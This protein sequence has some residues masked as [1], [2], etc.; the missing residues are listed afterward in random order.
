MYKDTIA[1][2]ATAMTNSGIGIVR[3]SGEDSF[4]IIDKIYHS[5]GNKKKLS[6]AESHTVHYGYI[7]DGTK[8]IDEV[9]VLI[10]KSPN[11]YTMEDTV[12][13]DC[14]GGSLVMKRVLETVIKYGARLAEP[15]EFTKRAFLNGRI[16][17]SQAESVMDLINAKN[18]F[19]LESSINQL[20][21]SIKEKIKKIRSKIIYQIAYIESALDDPEHISIDGYGEQLFQIVEELSNQ[22]EDMLIISENG[23]LLKEGINTVIIGKPNVGKS[24]LMNILAG[25]ERAIVTEIAGT[26]R[27]VLEEQI[28]LKGITLNL[29]DTAGIHDTKDIVE[30]IGVDKAKEFL[31][32]ADLVIYVADSSTVLD[33]DDKEILELLKYKK[34]V[35][36][37]NKT[38]LKQIT[39]EEKM[40]K[41]IKEKEIE[42]PVLSISAKKGIGIENLEKIVKDL[43]FSGEISFNDEIYIT[44]VRH[45]SL[46][47]SALKSLSNVKKSI[48]DDMPEDFYYIDLMS[49]YE[50]L[51]RIIGEA[52]GEDLVN[53]IFSRFC[54]GK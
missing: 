43:F 46:L 23:A 11:T 53:E 13:I 10:L 40:R 3:I 22:I 7:Y 36:L 18:N 12:E 21:G 47:Q 32:R 14:H 25:R 15:G 20:Q 51:G 41:V 39:T 48:E 44:N 30:K 24:S 6:M 52:V 29:I 37:L 33:K 5:K 4:Q 31:K 50:E 34:M 45:K 42:V 26:T 27:D 16:D 35:I 9:M 17:L 1:S 2:I 54:M 38:D 8:M 28:N 49:A 19:A